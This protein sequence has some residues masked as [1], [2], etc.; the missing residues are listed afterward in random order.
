M[1]HKIFLRNFDKYIINFSVSDHNFVTPL[2]SFFFIILFSNLWPKRIY[3]LSRRF[4]GILLFLGSHNI[5]KIHD[6]KWY[7]K[8]T[9]KQIKTFFTWKDLHTDLLY[10]YISA[11]FWFSKI[12]SLSVFSIEYHLTLPILYK[13]LRL[14]V[15]MQYSH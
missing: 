4:Q 15:T 8:D 14:A 11:K 2:N 7:V 3:Q 9:S 6:K 5:A 10:K 1:L 13:L 12:Q